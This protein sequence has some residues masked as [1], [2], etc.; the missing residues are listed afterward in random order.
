MGRLFLQLELHVG[1]AEGHVLEEDPLHHQVVMLP[2]MD[3]G[4]LVLEPIKGLHDRG[5]LDDL[6]AGPD[7][8]HDASHGR[9][10]KGGPALKIATSR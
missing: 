7:D 4:V 3:Q 2:A 1:L 6:R 8:R 5:H 9:F 10:R